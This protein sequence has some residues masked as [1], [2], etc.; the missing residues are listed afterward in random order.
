MAGNPSIEKARTEVTSLMLME[1]HDI[2]EQFVPFARERGIIDVDAAY[3]V[4]DSYARRIMAAGNTQVGGFKIGLTTKKMQEMCGIDQPVSGYVA[5]SRIYRAPATVDA[6]EYTHLGL[7]FEVAVKLAHDFPFRPVPYTQEEVSREIQVAPGVELVDDRNAD[8]ATLEALSLI[9]DNSWNAGIV[10][11]NWQD[12]PADLAGIEATITCNG[13]LVD[14]G[15]GRDALGHPFI[16][17]TWLANFRMRTDRPLKKGDI[18]LTG[19]L[20]RTQFPSEACK[21]HY[22]LAGLGAVEVDVQF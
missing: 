9:A 14:R 21:F 5:A 19:S 15:H 3:R 17:L 16:P 6:M 10:V 20:I 1:A 4:Q 22:A 7:E 18:V 8:Y 2:G 12:P 11:G 13:Q